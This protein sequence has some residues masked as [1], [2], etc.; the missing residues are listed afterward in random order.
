MSWPSARCWLTGAPLG[1][2]TDTIRATAT[3]LICSSPV[4]PSKVRLRGVTHSKFPS[5]ANDYIED[6]ID[7]NREFVPSPMSTE[8]LVVVG[9]AMRGVG[10]FDGDLVLFDRA[11]LP[12]SGRCVVALHEGELIV[13]RVQGRPPR[14]SIVVKGCDTTDLVRTGF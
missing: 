4:L 6:R 10:L 1:V 8:Q 13:R 9:D 3:G 14:V 5:P 12:S 2:P 11:K 7:L